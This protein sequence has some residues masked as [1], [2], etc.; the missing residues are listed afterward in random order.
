MNGKTK[1]PVKQEKSVKTAPLAKRAAP[2]AKKAAS[3]PHP[4]TF[5]AHA[6][7][8]SKVFLA[9]SFNKWAPAAIEMVDKTG[10]GDFTAT[11]NLPAGDHE[12]KFVIDGIWRADPLCADSLPNDQGTHNSVRHVS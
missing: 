9:G 3:K 2:A 11:L 7:V 8:G 12:Y 10:R 4:V 6:G 1:D 5:T